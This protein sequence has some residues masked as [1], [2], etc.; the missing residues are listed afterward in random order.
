MEFSMS[1]SRAITGIRANLAFD[2]ETAYS[3]EPNGRVVLLNGDV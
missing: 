2:P 3:P 1:A